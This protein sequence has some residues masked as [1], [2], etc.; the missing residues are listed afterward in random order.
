MRDIDWGF[1]I[2]YGLLIVVLLGF[3]WWRVNDGSPPPPDNVPFL[4]EESGLWCWY[5][6][7]NGL[8]IVRQLHCERR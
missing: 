8:T 1:L 3:M 7:E 4:H 2:P 6:R 5:T